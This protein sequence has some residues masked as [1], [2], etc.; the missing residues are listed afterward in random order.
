MFIIRPHGEGRQADGYWSQGPREVSLCVI[1]DLVHK[2]IN[3]ERTPHPLHTHT[4]E[5]VQREEPG[6]QVGPCS[7]QM[8]RHPTEQRR[9]CWR[10]GGAAWRSRSGWF[11]RRPE[12][13][14]H[15]GVAIPWEA[16][17]KLR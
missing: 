2:A 11:R 15:G 14:G 3:Q 17:E 9:W 12:G 13:R 10:P 1:K 8:L 16:T 7:A 6:G 4:K 5:K